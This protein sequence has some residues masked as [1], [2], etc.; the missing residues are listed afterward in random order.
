MPSMLSMPAARHPPQLRHRGDVLGREEGNA[1]EER[2]AGAGKEDRLQCE[3]PT[4]AAWATAIAVV[5]EEAGDAAG[6][7]RV[8]DEV[9]GVRRDV[10]PT[11]HVRGG[12][13]RNACCQASR[14]ASQ[15]AAPDRRT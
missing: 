1:V 11:W 15:T 5:R 8:D 14:V 3:V 2:R 12:P 7:L 6:V 9:L 10:L 13:A 4:A